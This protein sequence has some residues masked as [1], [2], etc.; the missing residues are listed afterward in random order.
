MTLMHQL[1]AG[2]APGIPYSVDIKDHRIT[3]VLEDVASRY[4]NRVA[5]D[6]FS[7]PTTYQELVKQARQGAT[8]LKRAGVR[9]GDRVAILMPNCPQHIVAVYAALYVGAVVVEH[10]PLAPEREIHESFDRH[11]ARVA[12]AWEKVV[13]KLAFLRGTGRVFA[14]DLTHAMPKVTR[15]LLSLPVKAAR[16]K[17]QEIS[18]P[19]PAY[20]PS[21]DTLVEHA[22]PMSGDSP[23]RPDDA[24]LLLHT[25]GTTGTPKAA[26]ITHRNIM[27]NVA[28]DIAWV[29]DLHEGSEVVYC[30][31]P[32]FH[33][34]G[35]GVSFMAGI[36][37]GATLALFPKF[38]TAMLLTAQKRLPCTFFVGV[39]PMYERILDAAEELDSDLTSVRFAISGAM[40]LDGELAARWEETSRGLIVE[41]YGMTEAS[42]IILGSPLSPARRPGTLGLPFPS[43]EVRIVN[44]DNIDE[45]VPD[46]QIGELI[47]KGPQ[48]FAG[49]WNREDE[50][51]QTLIDGWL[52]TGDL[53]VLDDGFITMADRR[54]EMIN[55][56]GFKV[57]PSQV[58]DAVR[59]MPGVRDVAVVGLPDKKSGE[60]VAAA[61]VLE[62]GA[63]VTLD[64]IRTWAEKSLSHYAL[65]RQLVVLNELPRSQIGKVMRRRVRED[66]LSMQSR[67]ADLAQQAQEVVDQAQS[68]VSAAVER[69]RDK[70]QGDSHRDQDSSRS[71]K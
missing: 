65:P 53:V 59:S 57:F 51:E 67:A 7:R 39:P 14:M 54:K 61:I 11:G 66:I 30:V 31:L 15:F 10:N 17:R 24:A 68:A 69:L 52:R 25:G 12:I 55:S 62:A 47:V 37:L 8:V 27:A 45:D 5:L 4:P 71:D 41:G 28:Q 3:D 63:S 40:P 36:R 26:T 1:Q 46:G 49:Y 2:Y 22:E 9:P 32:L 50:T 70:R 35:F 34:F 20:V 56:S 44:P 48:V 19:V 6:F 21:W 23:A 38:D 13:D 64:D 42:P 43:T 33:A 58:E 16:E 18:A 29:P 60:S